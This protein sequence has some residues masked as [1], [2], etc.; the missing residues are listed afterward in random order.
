MEQDN[1]YNGWANYAT[2]NVSLHLNNEYEWYKGLQG[3]V[4]NCCIN[5]TKL[6]AIEEMTSALPKYVAMLSNDDGSFGDL[7]ADELKEVYW[8]EIA[9]GEIDAEWTD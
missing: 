1:T 9:E 7:A 8:E 5:E 3:L 4:R 6:D 2:W